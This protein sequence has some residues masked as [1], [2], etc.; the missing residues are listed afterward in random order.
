MPTNSLVFE[1]DEETYKATWQPT[2]S[3]EACVFLALRFADEYGPLA[4]DHAPLPEW[5][6][7]MLPAAILQWEDGLERHYDPAARA[8]WVYH[9]PHFGDFCALRIYSSDLSIHLV[10][11][12]EVWQPRHG[13]GLSARADLETIAR[14][15][16]ASRE[17]TVSDVLA[18]LQE[19]A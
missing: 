11:Q 1:R 6:G 2:A 15:I 4:F 5:E 16:S 19:R 13:I 8:G 17:E 12:D 3:R 9:H 14:L 7:R 18:Q 10:A